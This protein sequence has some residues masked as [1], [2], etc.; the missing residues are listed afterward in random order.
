MS[1]G[2]VRVEERAERKILGGYQNQISD[3]YY[4]FLIEYIYDFINIIISISFLGP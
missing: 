4:V 3:V 2:H 1:Q